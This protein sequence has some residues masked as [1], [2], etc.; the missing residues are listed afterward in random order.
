MIKNIAFKNFCRQGTRALLN[1]IVI[2]LT[3]VAIVF[4]LSLYNGFQKQAQ[5]NMIRTDV[6]GG[7]YRVPGFDILTPTEWE[8][9]TLIIPQRLKSLSPEAK[10]E[11]LVLQGEIY[12]RRRL[13]PIQLRGINMDQM[14]LDL[15]LDKLKEETVDL[16]NMV[17]IILGSK[18]AKRAKLSL[19]DNVVLKWRD[20]LG[21]VD[22]L[23]ALIVDVV[24]L[25]NPRVDEGVVWL[26]LD[27][28]QQLTR[29]PQEISWVSVANSVG[30]IEGLVYLSV[31]ELTEDILNIIR[32]DRRYAVILWF[33]MI[34]LAGISVFNTQYLNIF[35][36]QKEIG[37]LMALGMKP[38]RIVNLFVFEGG[39]AAGAAIILGF[40]LGFLIL[41]WFQRV[42]LDVSH[43][44]ESQ[45][46][47]REN[48]FLEIKVWEVIA[49]ILVISS[50][51]VGISWI[52]VRKISKLN[53]TLALRGKGIT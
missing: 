35:K 26:R 28:L 22:A 23:D 36:R 11:V 46:P 38:Q 44:S 20:K 3:M 1:V 41:G 32:T 29:R 16:E 2:A 6:G 30:T 39:L 42:G 9:H 25:L 52:P 10:A 15:P 17:P 50:V 51:I 40:I 5:L 45:I 53:P 14:L 34:F 4:N 48:I 37:T 18:M 19:G 33:I 24:P 8:D 21:A 43:L 47:V 27:H 49:T 13:F 31:D 12:P 7:H